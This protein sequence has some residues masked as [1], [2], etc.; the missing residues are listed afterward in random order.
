MVGFLYGAGAETLILVTDA[1]GNICSPDINRKRAGI[2]FRE[3]CFGKENSLSLTEF[4]ANSV[5]SAKNSVSSLWHIDNRLKGAHWAL[6]PELGEAQ[7]NSLNSVFQTVLPETVFGPSPN[8]ETKPSVYTPET[9]R[10]RG[11][12][13]WRWDPNLNGGYQNCGWVYPPLGKPFLEKLG[14]FLANVRGFAK[15]WFPIEKGGFGRRSWTPKIGTTVQKMERWMRAQKT[16][17]R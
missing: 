17:R 2:L 9:K 4:R 12:G 5:S 16:E 10:N 3:Y 15:G 13:T 1:W 11:L 8:K 6:S 14:D 7:Q